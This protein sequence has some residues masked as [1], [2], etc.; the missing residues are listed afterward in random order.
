MDINKMFLDMYH[1]PGKYGFDPTKKK[2]AYV[3]SKDFQLL[4]N[5]TSP[6]VGY[7]FWDDVHPTADLHAWL[8]YLSSAIYRKK[9]EFTPVQNKQNIDE[10][11]D[12]NSIIN[13]YGLFI[14][15]SDNDSH[16]GCTRKNDALLQKPFR[17]LKMKA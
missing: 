2:L 12:I 15:P 11:K 17:K 6:S 14:S 13:R 3:Y 7:M 4:P 10:R 16:F 9:Y 1:Q 8:A 5:G